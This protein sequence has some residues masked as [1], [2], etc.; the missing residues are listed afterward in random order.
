MEEDQKEKW[1][2]HYEEDPTDPQ[3]HLHKKQCMIF[4]PAGKPVFSRYGNVLLLSS[5]CATLTGIISYTNN[6]PIKE[7]KIINEAL[8]IFETDSPLWYCIISQTNESCKVLRAQCSIVSHVLHSFI[9]MPTIKQTLD[10]SSNYDVRRVISGHYSLL[11]NALK[12]ANNCIGCSVNCT[13]IYPLLSE[14]R[15]F[16]EEHIESSV[17]VIEKQMDKDGIIF[18]LIFKNEQIIFARGRNNAKLSS[19]D[20]ITLITH[21]NTMRRVGKKVLQ[22]ICL[23]DFNEDGFVQSYFDFIKKGVTIVAISTLPESIISLNMLCNDIES[24]LEDIPFEDVILKNPMILENKLLAIAVT[25]NH[26]MYI[27]GNLTKQMK[28]D[29]ANAFSRNYTNEFIKSDYYYLLHNRTGDIEFVALSNVF[30][31]KDIQINLT[32]ELLNWFDSVAPSL[33][34]ESPPLW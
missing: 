14:Q 32:N 23:S 7:V 26:Q 9:P 34:L 8:I 16:I 31:S 30:L 19:R 6:D 21:I 1:L 29:I 13:T 5:Y 2:R 15:R 22:P 10:S 12:T 27:E 17:K 4:T 20:I 28:R 25:K 11:K 24:Y 33:W 18:V 3:F